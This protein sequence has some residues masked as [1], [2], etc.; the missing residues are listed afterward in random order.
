MI[1]AN[2]LGEGSSFGR[3]FLFYFGFAFLVRNFS[4]KRKGPE[5]RPSASGQEVQGLSGMDLFLFCFYFCGFLQII[6][7]DSGIL[8]VDF[9]RRGRTRGFRE[10]P[11]KGGDYFSRLRNA[12][13]TNI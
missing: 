1:R 10:L 3:S 8:D 12:G 2:I 7:M 11:F 9:V 4:A 13:K 6:F 5:P